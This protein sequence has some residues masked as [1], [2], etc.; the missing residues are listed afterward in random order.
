MGYDTSLGTTYHQISSDLLSIPSSV[1]PWT[2]LNVAASRGIHH[3][4]ALFVN[5]I[6]CSLMDQVKASELP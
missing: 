1:D 2:K 4:R 3:S 6:A 5:V